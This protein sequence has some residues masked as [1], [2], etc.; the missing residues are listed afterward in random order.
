[1]SVNLENVLKNIQTEK[2][3]K[4]KPENIRKGVTALGVQGT[5]QPVTVQGG[6][7]GLAIYLQD[8]TPIN[9]EGI[10]MNTDKTYD[11]I[12]LETQLYT[13][14]HSLI[15]GSNT[16]DDPSNYVKGRTVP[17]NFDYCT[18]CQRGNKFHFFGYWSSSVNNSSTTATLQ[19]YSYDF[20]TNVWTKHSDCPI[21]Q[22]GGYAVWYD[23]N[24]IVLLGNRHTNYYNYVYRYTI[25][26]DTWEQLEN[27][28]ISGWTSGYL[29]DGAYDSAN[30]EVYLHCYQTFFKYT[31]ST[32]TFETIMAGYGQYNRD[33]RMGLVYSSGYLFFPPSSYQGTGTKL[34]LST[35]VTSSIFSSKISNLGYTTIYSVG[36][37]LYFFTGYPSSTSGSVYSK[38][39]DLNTTSTVAASTLTET[40][41]YS[42]YSFYGSNAFGKVTTEDGVD[43]VI[44]FAESYSSRY[45]RGLVLHDKTYDFE[46]N[47]L[48]IYGNN[49]GSYETQMYLNSKV[50]NGQRWCQRFSNVY[51]WDAENQTMLKTLPLSYGN[52]T[53]WTRIR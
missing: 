19:H 3:T 50:I 27:V 38:Y 20:D 5:L 43:L 49:L 25:S 18:Y 51:L 8:E 7:V 16:E 10:W 33:Y 42:N 11:D 40:S 36:N 31:I 23:N 17:S 45:I 52:G 14:E 28:S 29:V 12:Y 26:T 9:P 6:D 32:G 44:F 46:N 1:M 22:G 34:N 4:L 53:D 21:P 47:T 15:Y 39:G 13:T 35:G 48:L 30:Q 41:S 2:N 37:R 24:N